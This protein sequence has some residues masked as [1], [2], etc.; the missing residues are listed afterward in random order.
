[1]AKQILV[2]DDDRMVLEAI[3]TILEDM[4]HCVTGFTDSLEG[5][6]AAL[7][8][9]YDLI[10][11]DLRLPVKDGAAVTKSILSARPEAKVLIITGHPTDPLVKQALDAGA[12]GILKKP[13]EIGKVLDHLSG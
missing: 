9:E 1:V 6:K 4:G 13:F 8:A 5:E 7:S 2:I 10:L 11:M 12:R 3:T